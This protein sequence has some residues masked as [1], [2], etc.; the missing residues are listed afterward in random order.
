[1]VSR[2]RIAPVVAV[3]LGLVV[4]GMLALT[5]VFD[6]LTHYPGT[7]GPLVDSLA[8]ACAGIPAASVATL[9][10]AR[11]PGNP[12]GWLLFGILFA[13][14]SPSN[15]YDILAYRMHHGTLPLGW[16]SVVFEELWPL[17]LVFV[18]ILLW[19]SRT[20]RCRA[21]GGGARGD[22]ARRRPAARRDGI[23][24]RGCGRGQGRR[25]HHGHGRP[26]QPARRLVRDP[27]HRGHRAVA[28]RLAGLDRHPDPDVPPGRR[29]APPAA[30]WLYSGAAV[31]LVAFV[32]GVFVVPLATGHAPGYPNNPVISALV[33][34]AFGAMPASLGVAV[35]KYRLYELDRIISRV[36]SYA[37][38]T[39]LLVGFYTG[40]VLL[41][42]H[43]LPFKSAVAVAACTLITAALFN[44]LR[45]RVQRAVD[46]R[47]NRS[48]YNAEAVVAAFTARMRQTVDFDA[49][50][51]DLVGVV[52]EA[53]QPTQVSMWLALATRPYPTGPYPTGRMPPVS[54]SVLRSDRIRGQ[55]CE[56]FGRMALPG[57]KPSWTTVSSTMSPAGA[58]S[59]VTW[60]P[61]GGEPR[62][63]FL[64]TA[65]AAA[66]PG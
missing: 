28:G 49:V 59:K 10:A 13:G 20:G 11:R 15:E 48:R 62:P 34:L 9:L 32:F 54:S 55:P 26:G 5:V 38:I 58:M 12:I 23:V 8:V 43:V 19:C 51:D 33:I 56:T 53:F 66:H 16:V 52:H 63:V 41:T 44:P 18:A 31:T 21:A 3:L 1:M 29:R 37:L 46:R 14:T 2:G 22:P 57:S 42:T 27:R 60:T 39:A 30:K 24:V 7:G 25:S 45:R 61:L 64:L 17:F 6:S 4:L 65:Q 47:F 36:V 35:L 50:R 40:L